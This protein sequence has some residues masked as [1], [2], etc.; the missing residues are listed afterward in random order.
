MYK[1]VT[2]LFII[3]QIFILFFIYEH[4]TMETITYFPEDPHVTMT[5]ASSVIQLHNNNLLIQ[6]QSKTNTPVRLRQDVFI[7]FIHMYVKGIGNIWKENI[8]ELKMEQ[9]VLLTKNSPID[10]L[11]YHYGEVVRDEAFTSIGKMSYQSSFFNGDTLQNRTTFADE[12]T[13]MKY[14]YKMNSILQRLQIDPNLYHTFPL[15]DLPLYEQTPFPN[16]NQ[17]DTDIIIGH[18]WEGLYKNYIIPM[19]EMKNIEK[20]LMPLIL[21]DKNK[22][23]LLVVYTINGKEKILRQNLHPN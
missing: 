15:I 10:V 16:M 1:K 9:S 11:S 18:L 7:V 22:E 19:T 14:M 5:E 23:H 3:I 20:S 12:Q 13:K 8:D 6:V 4:N 17:N 21:I 2:S